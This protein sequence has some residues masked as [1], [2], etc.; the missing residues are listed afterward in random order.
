MSAVKGIKGKKKARCCFPPCWELVK[1]ESP[2]RIKRS[3][4]TRLT[5]PLSS[6]RNKEESG[7]DSPVLLPPQSCSAQWR[8]HSLQS[9]RSHRGALSSTTL[10]QPSAV[11]HQ[12]DFDDGLILVSTL[13]LQF[14]SMCICDFDLGDILCFFCVLFHLFMW[15]LCVFVHIPLLL[16]VVEQ[17]HV[18]SDV[19]HCYFCLLACRKT[20]L[21]ICRAPCKAHCLFRGEED[22]LKPVADSHVGLSAPY[23]LV[24]LKYKYCLT[25]L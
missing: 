24:W 21:F 5:C 4:S 12:V 16:W 18:R 19:E 6:R 3:R 20:R 1:R 2:D 11:S 25:R 7:G 9:W 17:L 8:V 15:E 14:Y 22:W 23:H 13:L 10:P